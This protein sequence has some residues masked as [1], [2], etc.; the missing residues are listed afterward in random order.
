MQR[1]PRGRLCHT[2]VHGPILP[3]WDGGLLF[4]LA[5]ILLLAA[6]RVELVDEVYQIPAS[7]WRYV[8]LGLKQRP[9][10][11]SAHFDTQ[12]DAARVRLTLLRAEDLDKIRGG[13]PHGSIDSTSAGPR[14]ALSYD[15]P[16]PGDY[17]LV[18]DNDAPSPVAVRLNVWLDFARHGPPMTQLS[19]QRQLTVV[20]IS[21]AVFF[22]IVSFSARRLL[23][24]VRR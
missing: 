15:V 21:F 18:I 23:R 3:V 8:D 17:V 19:P 11:V 2:V 24:A 9:A 10:V 14:G 1:D 7:E 20:L 13:L 16:S 6:A 5:L 22:A 12:G 4:M